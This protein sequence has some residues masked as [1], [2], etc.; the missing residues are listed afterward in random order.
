MRFEVVPFLYASFLRY[1]MPNPLWMK[2]LELSPATSLQFHKHHEAHAAECFFQSGFKRAAVLV[3]DGR[4]ENESTTFWK[5]N[6]RELVL[7]DSKPP[8]VSVGYLYLIFTSLLGFR[9]GDEYKVMGLSSYG[10]P[11]Y[12]EEI[13]RL[14]NSP[15]PKML[16]DPYLMH[17]SLHAFGLGKPPGR[18]PKSSLFSRF[19][20]RYPLEFEDKADIA[21][22]LQWATERIVMGYAKKLQKI[23]DEDYLCLSGGVAQNSVLNGKIIFKAGFEKVFVSSCPNDAG[24][25]VGAAILSAFEDAKKPDF[26]AEYTAASPF[27]GPDLSIENAI[28]LSEK[29]G[30]SYRKLKEPLQIVSQLL[31]EGEVVGIAMG[32]AEFGPRALGHRSILA[33]PSDEDM[34]DRINK[35]KGRELFR[36]LAPSVKAEKAADYFASGN[37]DSPYMSFVFEAKKKT[38]QLAPAI[39]HVDG[40]SRIHTV[41][42]KLQP[43]YWKLLDCFEKLAGFPILLNTSLNIAGYPLAATEK[44]VIATMKRSALRYLLLDDYLVEK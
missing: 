23:T 9:Y 28:R 18:P 43:D 41:D 17:L 27:L 12:G 15:D 37:A 22:S 4:G 3:V 1:A 19:F 8:S 6:G 33:N 10:S 29:E 16:R 39:V 14:H 5:A 35:I 26:R 32:R 34:K 36:P 31:C 42:R 40:S 20:R 38:C 24:T 21:A 2:Y 25:A 7:L 44:D 13:L 30:F 11:V